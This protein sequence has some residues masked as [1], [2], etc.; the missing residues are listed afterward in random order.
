[1][2]VNTLKAP[3]KEQDQTKLSCVCVMK[4]PFCLYLEAT[5][6]HFCFKRPPFLSFWGDAIIQVQHCPS[7]QTTAPSEIQINHRKGRPSIEFSSQPS[8]FFSSRKAFQKLSSNGLDLAELL[9][10]AIYRSHWKIIGIEFETLAISQLKSEATYSSL[11]NASSSTLKFGLG[12]A[13]GD[14]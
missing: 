12:F 5:Y 7:D 2:P 1:V 11:P 10:Q 13:F 6:L 4:C 9:Q 8:I 14:R 3:I